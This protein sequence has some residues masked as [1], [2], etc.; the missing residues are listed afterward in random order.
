MLLLVLRLH[1]LQRLPTFG[2]KYVVYY[3]CPI[4]VVICDIPPVTTKFELTFYLFY[5]CKPLES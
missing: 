1:K 2:E 4:K 3:C 5:K